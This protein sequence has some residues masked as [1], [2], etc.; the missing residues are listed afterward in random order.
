MTLIRTPFRKK[1]STVAGSE[2]RRSPSTPRSARGSTARSNSVGSSVNSFEESGHVV[3][4]NTKNIYA[5]I[6]SDDDK[7][8]FATNKHSL[9]DEIPPELP[10]AN[11]A[12]K[13][14]LKVLQVSTINEC[15]QFEECTEVTEEDL[16]KIPGIVNKLNCSKN[17]LLLIDDHSMATSINNHLN[18]I[19]LI[20]KNLDKLMEAHREIENDFEGDAISPEVK[21]EKNKLKK[22]IADKIKLLKEARMMSSS[23]SDASMKDSFKTRV[24]NIFPK[25]EK[26][27]SRDYDKPK[28]TSWIG[29]GFLSS[30]LKKPPEKSSVDE[31]DEDFEEIKKV[32]S[33]FQ[34][35]DLDESTKLDEKKEKSTSKLKQKFKFNFKSKTK[36]SSV[37][38][39]CSKK[40]PPVET[41][42]D[43]NVDKSP[44]KLSANDLCACLDI[45]GEI[46]AKTVVYKDVSRFNF[47]LA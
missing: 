13:S 20:N 7:C 33:D 11:A 40:L 5:D 34:M 14:K 46:V 47:N 31:T 38:Q 27:E 12:P 42:L 19:D 45:D 16:F 39:R 2:G 4:S 41:L 26:Q 1:R 3:D 10:A 25:L 30:F 32:E 9:T 43:F 44:E 29:K 18:S 8:G 17:N 37:C 22:I 24:K 35:T 28:E 36:K 15:E 23:S 6:E 21:A